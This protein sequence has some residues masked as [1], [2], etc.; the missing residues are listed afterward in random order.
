MAASSAS[1]GPHCRQRLAERVP[2][3]S[4][5]LQR[6]RR[7]CQINRNTLVS[8]GMS[9]G[10]VQTRPLRQTDSTP[11]LGHADAVWSAVT[12]CT[13]RPPKEPDS[14]RSTVRPPRSSGCEASDTRS[15]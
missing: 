12:T 8:L 6:H 10:G 3:Q 1:S 14:M 5:F 13:T 9:R 15:L 4:R 7:L 2:G 11:Q